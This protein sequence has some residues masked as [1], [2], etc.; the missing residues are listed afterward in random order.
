MEETKLI[1]PKEDEIIGVV[2]EKTGGAHFKVF[3]SDDK[4]RLCRIPGS[5]KRSMWIDIGM[6][7]LVKPWVA[8]PKD[9]GDIIKKYNELQIKELKKRGYLDKIK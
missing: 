4:T 8:Q 6:I 1:L 7:V 3:C 2:E 9:R 5:K